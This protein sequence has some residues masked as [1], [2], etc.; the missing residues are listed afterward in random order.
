M[1][2]S[3]AY[4]AWIVVTVLVAISMLGCGDSARIPEEKADLT[5]PPRA[6]IDPGLFA[7]DEQVFSRAFTPTTG[8]GP[9][10][11]G[12]S[13]VS[14]HHDPTPGG[15]GDRRVSPGLFQEPTPGQAFLLPPSLY[16]LGFLDFGFVDDAPL[17]AGCG[18]DE[19]RGVHGHVGRSGGGATPGLPTRFG[20]KMQF[21]NLRAAVARCLYDEIGV[22][23]FGSPNEVTSLPGQPPEASAFE[24]SELIGFV[25]GL[26]VPPKLGEVQAGREAFERVGCA[27]CHPLARHGTDQCLHDL[28]DGLAGDWSTKDAT[29]REW[30]TR[31]LLGVRF[32]PLLHDGRAG[33]SVY[34]AVLAHRGNGSEANAVVDAFEGLSLLELVELLEFVGAQ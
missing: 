24:V 5:H 20:S 28:G 2:K 9:Q 16:G 22:T 15:S 17:E 23:N 34:A 31:P 19:A 32:H 14:C 6:G 7:G 18:V 10:W 1:G 29:A 33:M 3:R 8:L 30:G 25:D 11:N 13:C 4:P 26:D 27:V 21:V 12:V